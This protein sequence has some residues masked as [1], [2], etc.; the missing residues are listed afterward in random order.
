VVETIEEISAV[1]SIKRQ[2]GAKA[3]ARDLFWITC[4]GAY[5]QGSRCSLWNDRR[6]KRLTTCLAIAA[7][8][9]EGCGGDNRLPTAPSELTTG[10]VIYEHA[11][12]LGE[13]AHITSDIEN[14]ESVR[15]PCVRSDT[16]AN[17]NTS[18]TDSWDDCASSIRVAPGWRATLYEDPKF[19]GW[20]ADVG[21]ESVANYQLVR[22]PCSRDTFNDC[23]SSIRVFR[24]R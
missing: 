6:S 8:L 7:F 5:I 1:C 4:L 24:V 22:G 14:L 21:E 17:G 16:D 23:A 12:F 11:N 13:S 9:L 20:A 18:T 19:K 2:Y 15:G 3:L 10:V